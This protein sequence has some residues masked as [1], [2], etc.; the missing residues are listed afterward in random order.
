MVTTI[1][2]VEMGPFDEF[3]DEIG[4]DGE[5]FTAPPHPDD[6]LWRHPSEM[7]AL[8]SSTQSPLPPVGDAAVADTPGAALSRSGSSQRLAF[9]LAGVATLLLIAGTAQLLRSGDDQDT[10]STATVSPAARSSS[11]V[12]TPA[13][14]SGTI[15]VAAST[16]EQSWVT[17][18]RGRIEPQMPHVMAASDSSLKE[19]YGLFIDPS[20]LLLTSASLIADAETLIVRTASGTRFHAAVIGFDTE[21]D[22]A[23]LDIDGHDHPVADLS[24]NTALRVGQHTLGVTVSNQSGMDIGQVVYVAGRR[25]LPSGAVLYGTFEVDIPTSELMPGS[26][27]FTDT[28][29][30]VG[31]VSSSSSTDDNSAIIP[32]SFARRVGEDLH[33]HGAVR[34]AWLGA[35][36]TE[37]NA[38]TELTS[39]G[40]DPGRDVVVAITSL[41]TGGP[42]ELAG[43]NVEDYIIRL[44]G[45]R[46]SSAADVVTVLRDHAPGDVVTVEVARGG[47]RFVTEVETGLLT[48]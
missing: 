36:V 7:M 5:T 21:S 40:F 46:V 28:G 39:L 47:T 37:S 42:S 41:T 8:G 43:L 33:Q 44:D 18:L 19:G 3:E 17:A 22:L 25:E 26:A 12:S 34:R 32:I 23:L 1:S 6:R 31:I 35:E 48:D 10:V 27:V 45:Q 30:V 2:S 29:A 4:D 20:G 14:A 9:A 24:S 38:P 16:P 11:S 15:R 13:D